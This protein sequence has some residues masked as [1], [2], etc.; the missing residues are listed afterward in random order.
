MSVS[1]AWKI[2]P[3]PGSSHKNISFCS[4]HKRWSNSKAKIPVLSLIQEEPLQSL[5]EL[6]QLKRIILWPLIKVA[7]SK[8]FFFSFIRLSPQYFPQFTTFLNLRSGS[9]LQQIQVAAFFVRFTYM[10]MEGFPYGSWR[11]LIPYC[12]RILDMC[13]HVPSKTGKLATS[14]LKL[15]GWASEVFIERWWV[16]LLLGALRVFFPSMPLSLI[17]C[18]EFVTAVQLLYGALGFFL[19]FSLNLRVCLSVTEQHLPAL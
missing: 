10:P 8:L 3:R 5:N 15:S 13:H 17:V 2:I 6:V 16:P 18:G 9:P 11:T 4:P 14:L 1:K 19:F 12:R 7:V